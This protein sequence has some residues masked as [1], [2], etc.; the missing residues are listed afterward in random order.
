MKKGVFFDSLLLM[1][2]FCI[3]TMAQLRVDVVCSDKNV[4]SLPV[5]DLRYFHFTEMAGEGELDG[6]WFLGCTLKG[7]TATH[8][9]ATE[10]LIFSAGKMTWSKKSAD[11]VYNVTYPDGSAYTGGTFK[12][13]REGSAVDMTYQILALDNKMLCFKQGTTTYFFYRTRDLA[14]NSGAPTRVP[15]STPESLWASN[16]KS[17]NSHSSSTPMGNHYAQYGAATQ[18]QI[19]WLANPDNQ[20]TISLADTGSE[21]DRWTAKT[22]TL[23]PFGTPQPAD[24]NQHA[25]GDCCMCASF[26]SFAYVYPMWI[27]EKVIEQNSSTKFTVHMFDPKGNAID[28]VVDNK[29]LCNSSGG[30][31]QVSGKNNKYNWASIMEKALMKWLSCFQTGGLGGIGTEHA[32][33]PF[34]GNGDSY[35]FDWGKLYNSELRMIVEYQLQNG[36]NIVGGFHESDHVCGDPNA[37]TVTGHAFTAMIRDEGSDCLFVMRNPWGQGGANNRKLDGKLLIPDDDVVPRLID[38]RILDPGS[39][40]TQYKVENIGGYTVPNFKPMYMDLNPSKEMLRMYN[41]IDYDLLPI[42]EDAEPDDFVEE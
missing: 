24:V 18:T 10:V 20:P 38:I 17:G 40:M 37:K 6:A 4:I 39:Q 8:Y 16:L 34:T 33:P 11:I 22:I 12:G 2:T 31:A 32:M 26:A 28:V 35:A 13:R 14:V 27:K 21:Y 42:P 41:V 3:T 36:K 23:Y 19:D 25:I 7:S 5:S 29:L 15:Y 30:C 1:F 9:D